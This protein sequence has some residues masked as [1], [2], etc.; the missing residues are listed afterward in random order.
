[1]TEDFKPDKDKIAKDRHEV[2]E[3]MNEELATAEVPA[4]ILVSEAVENGP[5][6]L[7][8]D[9]YQLGAAS[10]EVLGE[11]YF[12]PLA[13]ENDKVGYFNCVIT[14]SEELEQAYL[15][16]LYEAVAVLDFH[17]MLGSFGVSADGAFLSYKLTV[18]YALDMDKDTLFETV[19]IATGN[20]IAVCD[21]WTDMMLRISEGKGDVEDVKS[22]FGM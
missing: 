1:M 6:I 7:T 3:R 8:V 19:N 9:L 21:Q 20:A 16:K 5:E 17:L 18:P 22:A 4:E 10:D 13:T 15:G 12:T 2:L 14:L 11:F